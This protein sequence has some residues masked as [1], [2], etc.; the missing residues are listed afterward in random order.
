MTVALPCPCRPSGDPTPP[1]DQP[2]G[3]HPWRR[4]RQWYECV[5]GWPTAPT[6]YRRPPELITG[7]RFDALGMPA[8]AGFAVLDRVAATGPVALDGRTRTMWFL[9]A[10]G[11]ADELPGLLGWLEWGGVALELTAR[12]AG[13]RIVAPEPLDGGFWP[14]GGDGGPG[15]GC[16]TSRASQ[17]RY[18]PQEAAEAA[19]A[20]WVRPP[21]PGR[22]VESTLPVAGLGG[23]GGAPDLVR[24]V[25]AAATECH[26]ARL[27]RAGGARRDQPPGSRPERPGDRAR[28]PAGDQALAFSY[29]SR[30]SAGTRPRSFTL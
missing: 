30:M 14:Q 29:A 21:E 16:G 17:G 11:S 9:T 24:L 28:D 26:R 7:V 19:E 12:G 25:G 8:E 5:L 3:P 1:G 13:G 4:W 2:R 22:D 18:D 15:R 23:D 6:A 20:V 10:A 27:L